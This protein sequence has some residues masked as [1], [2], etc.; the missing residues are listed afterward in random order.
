MYL[1]VLA[2]M[3]AF[4]SHVTET[5]SGFQVMLFRHPRCGGSAMQSSPPAASKDTVQCGFKPSLHF[6]NHAV[7]LCTLTNV[8]QVD[9][10][11]LVFDLQVADP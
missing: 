5:L 8:S 2:T 6:L 3:T 7:L 10:F 1:K 4:H 9:D 11:W